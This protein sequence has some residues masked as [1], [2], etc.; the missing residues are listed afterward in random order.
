MV[1]QSNIPT[2]VENQGEQILTI[3]NA[4]EISQTVILPNTTHAFDLTGK[5]H[6]LIDDK[7]AFELVYREGIFAVNTGNA[8]KLRNGGQI[9]ITTTLA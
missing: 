9:L 8:F 5:H 2:I 4:L 3:I 1:D 6:D 7:I